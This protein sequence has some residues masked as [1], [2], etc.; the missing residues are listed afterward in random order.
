M[1][2][3]FNEDLDFDENELN[4]LEK[5][6]KIE[7][8]EE[9][10]NKINFLNE[11]LSEYQKAE[12]YFQKNELNEGKERATKVINQIKDG[13]TKLDTEK[14][15]EVKE[16][17]F[18]AITPPFIYN[19]SSEERDKKFEVIM[20]KINIKIYENNDNK[21][22]INKIKAKK[23][24]LTKDSKERIETLE[25]KYDNNIFNY[26]KH[27]LNIKESFKKEWAPPPKFEENEIIIK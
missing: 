17:D 2:D 6:V 12:E 9:R 10:K 23:E 4:Y 16:S 21:E 5:V 8:E 25:K 18:P 13:L 3:T 15:K 20:N 27:L 11:R 24:K 26:K 19:C 22:R 1:Q 14:W 7:E